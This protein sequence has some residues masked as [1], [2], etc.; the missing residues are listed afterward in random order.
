MWAVILIL[1]LVL[2]F[3]LYKKAKPHVSPEVKLKKLKPEWKESKESKFLKGATQKKNNG[4][5]EGA[6]RDLRA[7]Y[8]IYDR[9]YIIPSV[10]VLLRLPSYLQLAGR[11]DE[12]W[13]EYNK[14]I[15]KVDNY[16]NDPEIAPMMYS[17]IYDKMRLFLQRENKYEKAVKFGVFSHVM[18]SMGLLKQQR[19]TELKELNTTAS[20]RNIANKLLRKTK[21]NCKDEL[22]AIMED[23]VRRLPSI[24]LANLG[25]N[26]DKLFH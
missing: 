16:W 2:G 26:V 17:K 21:Y 25:R 18:W 15:V 8:E 1:V 9:G 24:D 23:F 3:V 6:I 12:A 7:A 20:L 4:N 10:D 5:L 22:V 14:L 13:S 19:K 11:K